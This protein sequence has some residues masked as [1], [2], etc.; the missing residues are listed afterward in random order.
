MTSRINAQWHTANPMPQR[1]NLDQ[2]IVWHT[3]HA[4]ACACRPI[5]TR[6]AEEMSRRGL[7]I[8]QPAKR[9]PARDETRAGSKAARR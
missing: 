8:P 1:A 4:V 2:R 6:L 7:E 5:P 3:A 9:A